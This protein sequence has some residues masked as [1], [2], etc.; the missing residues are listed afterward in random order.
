MDSAQQKQSA[1]R[2]SHEHDNV[3]YPFGERTGARAKLPCR[4]NMALQTNGLTASNITRVMQKPFS[5]FMED[6][7]RHEELPKNCIVAFLAVLLF[8]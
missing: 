4:L 5:S 6:A 8:I 7:T 1:L 2:A 3:R